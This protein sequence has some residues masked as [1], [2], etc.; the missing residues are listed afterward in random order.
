MRKAVWRKRV[1]QTVRCGLAEAHGPH[2]WEGWC[3]ALPTSLPAHTWGSWKQQAW[4]CRIGH[5]EMRPALHRQVASSHMFHAFYPP[6]IEEDRGCSWQRKLLCW[7][8]I[9]ASHTHPSNDTPISYSLYYRCATKC[10]RPLICGSPF[11]CVSGISSHGQAAGVG[12]RTLHCILG[13]YRI[14]HL[15]PPSSEPE[16][17]YYFLLQWLLRVPWTH[18]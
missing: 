5:P 2:H 7:L 8:W 1:R 10:K 6:E 14:H 11:C 18:H 15:I 13:G 17:G 9:G 4:L 3:H 12:G 16:G